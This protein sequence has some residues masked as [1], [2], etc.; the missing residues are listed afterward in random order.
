MDL[1]KYYYIISLELYFIID[2]YLKND[3]GK[4]RQKSRL[5]DYCDL[6]WL[7]AL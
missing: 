7:D 1:D 3:N 5:I 4:I 2:E 6:V